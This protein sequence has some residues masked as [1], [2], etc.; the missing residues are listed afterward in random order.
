MTSR[1]TH[2]FNRKSFNQW[3]LD[4]CVSQF[5]RILTK[6]LPGFRTAFDLDTVKLLMSIFDTDRS[7]T[8]GFNE[9][10]F[11]PSKPP[12][13]FLFF[14]HS[15]LDFGNTLRIGKVSSSTSTRTVPVPSTAQNFMPP[16]N[17]LDIIYPLNFSSS[18][19]RSTVMHFSF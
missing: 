5:M 3:R 14:H 16:S 9:V 2:R 11:N 10:R 15:S 6:R 8:I 7:G 4:S 19:R 18:W 1:L 13:G 17:N 12:P